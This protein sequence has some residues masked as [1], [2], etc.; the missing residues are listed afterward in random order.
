[1][2]VTPSEGAVRRRAVN[3]VVSVRQR[4]HRRA[5]TLTANVPTVSGGL[6]RRRNRVRDS[7]Q[8]RPA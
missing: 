4:R 7:G 1:M 5:P 8:H 3:A 2:S 6:F